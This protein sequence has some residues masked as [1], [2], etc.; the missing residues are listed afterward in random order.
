MA[1]A[2]RHAVEQ[3]NRWDGLHAFET[4]AWDGEKLGGGIYAAID[5]GFEIGAYPK[6]MRNIAAR[7]LIDC[8]DSPACAYLL[9]MEAHSVE[10]PADATP[11]QRRQHK[12]D[13]RNRVLDKRPDAREI[14]IAYVADVWGRIWIARKYRDDD[15]RI[16]ESFHRPGPLPPG[17]FQVVKGLAGVARE[18]G[19]IAWGL[20][21]QPGWMN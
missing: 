4:L 8:P 17:D 3:H 13:M 19:A 21:A 5:P 7:Q 15:R 2:A 9:L 18:T 12:E 1:D 16:M 14:C 6:I 20:P 11:A 10:L